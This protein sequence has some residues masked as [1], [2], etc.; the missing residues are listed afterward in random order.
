MPNIAEQLAEL[1]NTVDASQSLVIP[2]GKI[3]PIFVECLVSGKKV[4]A[5]GNGGSASDAMHLVEE[6]VGRYRT[7]RRALPAISLSTDPT[8]LTC[9]ANDWGYDEVFK[10]QVEAHGQPGDFFVCFSTSGNSPSI[11]AALETARKAKLRTLAMLGK[12]GGK[13]KGMAEFELIV[14]SD[15]TA[16]IQEIHTWILHVLLEAIE[17][18]LGL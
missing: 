4:L 16:R 2:L 5:C 17:E 18:E 11:L 6:L 12:N 9:I 10:R 8:V 15:N 3:I 7:N 1:R 13:A 14:P